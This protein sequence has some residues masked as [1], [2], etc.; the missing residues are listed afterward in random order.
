[1]FEEQ[2]LI[3]F[4]MELITGISL[5]KRLEKPISQTEFRLW[6]QQLFSALSACE[7]SGI[8][9]GDIKPD[10]ILIDEHSNLR[11]IDFGIGHFHNDEL[12]TSGHQ[13]FSAPEVI[14]SGQSSVQSELYSAGKIIQLMLANISYNTLSMTARWW[15]SKQAAFVAQL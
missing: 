10:N 15:H 2:G 12:Q 6:T 11:L 4:T 1:M 14:Y 3:F 5:I 7:A 9:H 13:D 8:K